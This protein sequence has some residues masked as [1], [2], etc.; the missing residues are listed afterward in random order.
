M[1]TA[2]QRDQRRQALSA[3]KLAVRAYAR[4]PSA[5]NARGVQLAWR[6]VRQIDS[7]ARWQRP[8]L[9]TGLRADPLPAE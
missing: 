9:V 5:A 2:T 3:A 6:R 7:M 1:P 4:D 8:R